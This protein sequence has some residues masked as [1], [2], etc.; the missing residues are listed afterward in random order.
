MEEEEEEE[1]DAD[2]ADRLKLG[3]ILHQPVRA[4]EVLLSNWAAGEDVRLGI[5]QLHEMLRNR[6]Q[7]RFTYQ[8]PVSL[9]KRLYAKSFGCVTLAPFVAIQKAYRDREK[10]MRQRLCADQTHKLK[11]AEEQARSH[12]HGQAIRRGLD[13]LRKYKEDKAQ[14]KQVL[15]RRE[16]EHAESLR[17]IRQNN[18][19]FLEE[20]NQRALEQ[21]STRDFNS[22][23]TM[24]SETLLKKQIRE[25]NENIRQRNLD[26]A[27]NIKM[28]ASQLK[29]ERNDFMVFRQ[30]AM[31]AENNATNTATSIILSQATKDRL[32]R[33]RARV[34]A[35]K[36]REFMAEAPEVAIAKES[37]LHPLRLPG[38]PLQP[39][40]TH[41]EASASKPEVQ[42]LPTTVQ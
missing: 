41:S 26:L 31:Q 1:E 20:K 15:Q 12:L 33:A 23:Y 6:P 42:R 18:I 11:A 3:P 19:L 5:Q 13:P 32:L 7:P 4:R 27:R 10:A 37:T 9:D 36:G 8:P 25:K 14:G 16:A 38:N 22:H 29:R 21:Q 17:L 39:T 2:R 35:Q 24:M 34:A 30:L 28:Q 40:P